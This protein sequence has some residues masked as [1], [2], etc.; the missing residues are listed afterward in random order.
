MFE[1]ENLL[2][3]NQIFGVFRVLFMKNK[4]FDQVTLGRWAFF[5]VVCV[6][7]MSNILLPNI[8]T[9]ERIDKLRKSSAD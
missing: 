3:F 9:K 4:T 2:L 6:K 8:M 1:C 7:C 5:T